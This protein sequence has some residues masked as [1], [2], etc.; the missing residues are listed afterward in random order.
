MWSEERPFHRLSFDL[1]KVLAFL[2]V[3]VF[4]AQ[5]HPFCPSEIL[6]TSDSRLGDLGFGN[7]FLLEAHFALV[8]SPAEF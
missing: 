4:S 2:S 3:G 6:D 8:V 7:N 5:A 1:H